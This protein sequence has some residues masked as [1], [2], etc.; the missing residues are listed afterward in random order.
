MTAIVFET[1]GLIDLRAFTI[2]GAHAK[3]KTDNPIV[4]APEANW[5]H[6]LSFPSWVAP[7]AAFVEVMRDRKKPAPKSLPR[8]FASDPEPVRP[9]V[10]GRISRSAFSYF[11]PRSSAYT[12]APVTAPKAWSLADEHPRPWRVEE[13]A[14]VDAKGK[15]LFVIPDDYYDEA[16]W[17][18]VADAVVRRVNMAVALPKPP[19]RPEETHTDVPITVKEEMPF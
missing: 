4:K 18:R 5:E 11:G 3:P 12:P 19:T 6:D 1:P 17:A 8:T 9:V 2:M 14:V 16:D 13:T 7:S 10:S 15:T